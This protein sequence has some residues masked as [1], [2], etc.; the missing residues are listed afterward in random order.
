LRDEEH[1]GNLTVPKKTLKNQLEKELKEKFKNLIFKL[2]SL[3]S[4]PTWIKDTKIK[5]RSSKSIEKRKF[6]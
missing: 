6:T 2:R 3:H 5:V 1:W 4:N